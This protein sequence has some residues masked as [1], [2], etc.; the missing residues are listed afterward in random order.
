MAERF[1]CRDRYRVTQG[2]G[3]DR[4]LDVEPL[5]LDLGAGGEKAGCRYLQQVYG[6]AG[7]EASLAARH[8]A[9]A[10]SWLVWLDPVV[11]SW[12]SVLRMPV[13]AFLPSRLKAGRSNGARRRDV[14]LK[15]NSAV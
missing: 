10:R 5:A 1:R 3:A 2:C 8:G 12:F 15:V 11:Q 13:C 4:G 7:A 14:P 9:R 6:L